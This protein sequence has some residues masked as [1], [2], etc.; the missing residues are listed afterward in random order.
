MA[1]SINLMPELGKEEFKKKKFV[2]TVNLATIG[3]L[4]V[5]LVAVGGVFAFKA[6]AKSTYDKTSQELEE[7]KSIIKQNED[8]EI[9]INEVRQ[10]T[11]QLRQIFDGRKD[12]VALISNLELIT[13]REVIFSDLTVSPVGGIILAGTCPD[14]EQLLGY[15][16][17]LSGDWDKLEPA[18]VT[19]KEDL[20]S[21]VSLVSAARDEATNDIRF[22][23][24]MT[25]LKN[26]FSTVS[27]EGEDN[28]N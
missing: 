14:Y 4:I 21:K 5:T 3:I 15:V 13:P 19:E 20:F 8:V 18:Q 7:Q 17:V 22:S 16:R 26:A 2:R 1:I 23:I 24:D 25:A 27:T 9:K 10:R 28:A 6:A 11:S 12:F